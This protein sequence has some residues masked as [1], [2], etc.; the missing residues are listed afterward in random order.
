MSDPA[1]VFVF[2]VQYSPAPGLFAD[3]DGAMGYT[4]TIPCG[5]MDTARM[6]AANLRGRVR[7]IA[8]DLNQDV[9]ELTWEET[10]PAK[11]KPDF[12]KDAKGPSADHFAQWLSS[13]GHSILIN[14]HPVKP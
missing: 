14:R 10:D 11:L 3:D 4:E 5:S 6:E 9:D 13:A 2:L 7:R 8:V 12:P 1:L